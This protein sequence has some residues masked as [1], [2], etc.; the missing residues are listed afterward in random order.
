MSEGIRW[1]NRIRVEREARGL[2]QTECARRVGTTQPHLSLVERQ[3]KE[4][5]VSTLLRLAQEFDC[6]LD[7]LIEVEGSER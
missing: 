4:P 6:T 2:T 5:T 7:A 1:H 3:E